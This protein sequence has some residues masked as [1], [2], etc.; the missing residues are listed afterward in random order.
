VD[1]ELR[2][3]L[4]TSVTPIVATGQGRS[5]RQYGPMASVFTSQLGA[6]SGS[7]AR[8]ADKVGAIGEVR[9]S[10][11]QVRQAGAVWEAQR[12]PADGHADLPAADLGAASSDEIE[13]DTGEAVAALGVSARHVRRLRPTDQDAL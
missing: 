5:T 6:T 12:K 3:P 10:L 7:N 8:L 9:R 11:A 13:I 2:V 1:S 4:L